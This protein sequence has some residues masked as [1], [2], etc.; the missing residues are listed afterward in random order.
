MLGSLVQARCGE[1]DVRLVV[2]KDTLMASQADLA[3]ASPHLCRCYRVIAP[4]N[5]F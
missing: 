1:E 2:G 4:Q 3:A 5:S